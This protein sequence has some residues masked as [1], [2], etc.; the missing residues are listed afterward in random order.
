[1]NEWDQ[2]ILEMLLVRRKIYLKGYSASGKEIGMLLNIQIRQVQ[3][4]ENKTEGSTS[5]QTW[6]KCYIEKN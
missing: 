6:S 3:T 1:M 5:R 2:K 4:S